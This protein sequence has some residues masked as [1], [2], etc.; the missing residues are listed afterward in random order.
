MLLF[1][2]KARFY[3]F[4][5]MPSLL[6]THFCD[7]FNFCDSLCK[8]PALCEC[9]NIFRMLNSKISNFNLQFTHDLQSGSFPSF[10]ST[11]ISIND[12]ADV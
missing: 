1:H 4:L 3:I 8:I 5:F 9:E 11:D 10:G 2:R 12:K 6:L 7:S